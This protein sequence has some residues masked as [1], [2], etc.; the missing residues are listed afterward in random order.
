MP[1]PPPGAT[2]AF[3][4]MGRRSAEHR[5]PELCAPSGAW[6]SSERVFQQPA[7]RKAIQAGGQ[8]L[9]TA[10]CRINKRSDRSGRTVPLIPHHS[11]G[12]DDARYRFDAA[13]D[14]GRD[15]FT[16]VSRISIH[17]DGSTR[18]CR[19]TL[20]LLPP[21]GRRPHGGHQI[22][23]R[24][25]HSPSLRSGSAYIALFNASVLPTPRKSLPVHS[26]LERHASRPGADGVADSRRR[27]GLGHWA[28]GGRNRDGG[29]GG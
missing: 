26:Q 8:F 29:S 28:R 18:E 20:G 9:C 16:P 25:N 27:F 4:T 7:R 24:N 10:S 1:H 22:V 17:A 15:F 23:C 2:G 21:G 19:R 13:P 6:P 12:L 3:G 5:C 11:A 14:S